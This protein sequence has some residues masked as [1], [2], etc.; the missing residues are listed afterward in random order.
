MKRANFFIPFTLLI[1]LISAGNGLIHSAIPSSSYD[2][3]LSGTAYQNPIR[4]NIRAYINE[5]EGSGT[6]K[7]GK[8]K[9]V[10]NPVITNVYKDAEYNPLIPETGKISLKYWRVLISRD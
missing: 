1:L 7:L 6:I 5:L 8:Q 3:M 9:I 4:E 2:I 10:R